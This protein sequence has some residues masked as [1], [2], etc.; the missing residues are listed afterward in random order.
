[1]RSRE[2]VLRVKNARM[3]AVMRLDTRKWYASSLARETGMSYVYASRMLAVFASEGLIELKREGKTRRASLTESG[4]RVANALD[5]ILA[6]L[7]DQAEAKKSN[8]P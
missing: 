1:M 7:P 5:E 4:L 2:A 6:R 8:N 3:L